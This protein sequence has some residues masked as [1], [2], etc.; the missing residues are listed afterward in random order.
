MEFFTNEWTWVVIS[1]S[2][3]EIPIDTALSDPPIRPAKASAPATE[4]IS[5]SSVDNRCTAPPL[6]KTPRP[7]LLSKM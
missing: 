7:A 4:R 2:V 5:E 1:L 6:A 3:T